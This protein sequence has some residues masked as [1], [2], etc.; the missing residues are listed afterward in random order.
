MYVLQKNMSSSAHYPY[1]VDEAEGDRI[2][3]SIDLAQPSECG[4][5]SCEFSAMAV[6]IHAGALVASTTD[7]KVV[8]FQ[9]NSTKQL[10]MVDYL[11]IPP[12]RTLQLANLNPEWSQELLKQ[13]VLCLSDTCASS[14]RSSSSSL[15]SLALTLS[16]SRASMLGQPKSCSDPGCSILQQ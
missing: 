15:S 10:T 3:S 8:T 16:I 7:H 12:P 13:K 11:S 14:G 2:M 4:L 5:Q 6:Q 1:F 9:D